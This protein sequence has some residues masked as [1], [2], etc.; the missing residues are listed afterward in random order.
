MW[1]GAGQVQSITASKYG[2]RA[3]GSVALIAQ[4]AS[5]FF[6]SFFFSSPRRTSA[7]TL[8]TFASVCASSVT[9]LHK[10]VLKLCGEIRTNVLP[11]LRRISHMG[12]KPDGTFLNGFGVVLHIHLSRG[13]MFEKPGRTLGRRRSGLN[14]RHSSRAVCCCLLSCR[15]QQS[16][17]SGVQRLHRRTPGNEAAF[18]LTTF[19]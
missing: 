3:D 4:G 13:G 15:Y 10:L 11:L 14:F 18:K 12:K 5:F 17:A 7:Y 1:D 8:L 6:L 19:S 9:E 16:E 2:T